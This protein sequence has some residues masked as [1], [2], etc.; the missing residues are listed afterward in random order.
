MTN[1][2]ETYFDAYFAYFAA[3]PHQFYKKECSLK[4]WCLLSCQLG[5]IHALSLE[6]LYGR[7][8]AYSAYQRSTKL[9]DTATDKCSAYVEEYDSIK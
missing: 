2:F 7:L 1:C 8:L 6:L 4:I 5:K 3:E 9:R